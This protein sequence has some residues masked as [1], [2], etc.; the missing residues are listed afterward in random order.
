M[1]SPCRLE[2]CVHSLTLDEVFGGSALSIFLSTS[3]MC[4]PCIIYLTLHIRPF[5]LVAASNV[6]AQRWFNNARLNPSCPCGVRHGKAKTTLSVL[7]WW[8]SECRAF[9]YS[10]WDGHTRKR[11]PF[12]FLR[13]S[14]STAPA[15]LRA[16]LLRL[17]PLVR[18]IVD[19]FA[20]SAP[21]RTQSIRRVLAER[22]I[23]LSFMFL[24]HAI[25]Q[26][27]IPGL[28]ALIKR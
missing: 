6:S 4:H 19:F 5:L 22:P 1:A 23:L 24:S 27:I 25:R 3:A 21:L 7:L 10:S 9:V 8:R 13:R 2:A 12:G 20:P 17:C 14:T 26:S 16:F 15:A 28:M 11:I 18:S